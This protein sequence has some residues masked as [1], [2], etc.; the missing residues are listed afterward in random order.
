[1][2]IIHL[3]E[4]MDNKLDLI[5]QVAYLLQ[6]SDYVCKWYVLNADMYD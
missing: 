5:V 4:F 3:I 1:M 2:Y 6:Y